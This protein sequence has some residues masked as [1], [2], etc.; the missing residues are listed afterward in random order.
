MNKKVIF[1]IVLT[2]IALFVVY[3]YSFGPLAKNRLAQNVNPQSRTYVQQPATST[4]AILNVFHN[5]DLKENYY[6]VA[7]PSDWKLDTTSAVVGKYSFILQQG[8]AEVALQDVADN[9]TLELFV[10]SQDEP[11]IKKDVVGYKR[12]NYQKT[13]INGNA[14]YQLT[15]ASQV[16]G[17]N[18]VTERTYITGTDHAGV[19]TIT[20][21]EAE[22]NKDTALINA[23]NGS[24]VWENTI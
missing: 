18:M 1:I 24:F 7:V 6:S 12:V 16:G 11:Q 3:L 10:L 22:F 9:T 19:V 5:K 20:L 15:Y 4:A 23:L 8:H 21:P 14:A 2:L 13:T 17:Q